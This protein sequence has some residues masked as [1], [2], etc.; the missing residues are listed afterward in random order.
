MVAYGLHAAW[1][2]G[3]RGQAYIDQFSYLPTNQKVKVIAASCFL[4]LLPA[5]YFLTTA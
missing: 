3:S 4:F 5:V 1:L 2:S